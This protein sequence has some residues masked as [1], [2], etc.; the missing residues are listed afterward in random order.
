MRCRQRSPT[1]ISS[2]TSTIHIIYKWAT[3]K[4]DSKIQSLSWWW[5]THSRNRSWS[6][7]WWY[8][9]W[10]KQ[11]SWCETMVY[12][13]SKELETCTRRVRIQFGSNNTKNSK[14]VSKMLYLY[15]R[16]KQLTNKK[17]N[18]ITSDSGEDL[19]TPA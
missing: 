18:T 8:A 12:G 15:N 13:A 1:R 6:E 4:P 16:S 11:E 14:T 5:K 10:Y 9:T 17:I 3:D 19:S 7:R 2:W